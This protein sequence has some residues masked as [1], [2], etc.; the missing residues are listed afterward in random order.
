[1]STTARNIFDKAISVIDELSDNGTVNDAQVKEYKNRAPYLID[2]FQKEMADEGRLYDIEEYENTDE[3]N[4][5]KW[6][7]LV[8]PGEMKRI[9]EVI[10]VDSDSQISSI[11]YKKFG[12]S[13]I[14]FYFTKLGMARMLYVPIP[15]E[16]TS[17][18]QTLQIADDIATMGAYYLAE[19]FAMA[20]MMDDLAARCRNKYKELKDG[21]KDDESLMPTEIEDVYSTI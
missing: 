11:K 20:D 17:I 19:H 14:Y 9:K 10:F 4:V 2:M 21:I 13:D 1:M 15:T 12:N 5:F 8:L 6:T 16:I 3:T 7:K 18:D